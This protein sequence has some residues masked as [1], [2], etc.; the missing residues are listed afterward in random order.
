MEAKQRRP[1]PITPAATSTPSTTGTAVAP[2]EVTAV[3]MPDNRTQQ[4]QYL[5]EIDPA[6]IVGRRIKFTK[7]ATFVTADDNKLVEENATFIALCD[8][9]LVGYQ[10]FYDDGRQPDRRMVL[11]YSPDFVKPDRNALGD[12]NEADWPLG[13]SGLP[14][15]PWNHYNFVV[16]QCAKTG[17]LFTFSTRSKTGRRAVGSLLKHFDRMLRTHPDKLPLVRLRTGGFMHAD[18]RI[19]FIVTPLFQIVDRVPRDSAAK[20]PDGSTANDMDDEIPWK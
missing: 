16:L 3:A 5:D 11:Y 4:Q 1:A 20:P 10:R 15:D 13:L 18:E 12:L 7:E 17:A 8:Q 9:T 19:G 2:A 6:G 14:E